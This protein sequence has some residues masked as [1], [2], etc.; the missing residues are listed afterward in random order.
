MNELVK[1]QS[2]LPSTL[3]DLSKFVLIGSEKL[4]VIKAEIKAI[5]KAELA[6]EVYYQKLEEQR[7][8]SDLILD[9]STRM[10]DLSKNL[11]KAS[12]MRKDVTSLLR[13]NEVKTKTEILHNLGFSRKQ[14]HEFEILAENKDLVELEKAK[15]SEEKRPASRVNVVELAKQR[16]KREE[17]ECQKDEDFY[18][19]LDFCGKTAKK[20]NDVIFDLKRLSVDDRH[21]T[22]WARLLDSRMVLDSQIEAVEVA[23]PKLI[24]IQKFLKELKI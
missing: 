14:A 3:D 5:T 13:G 20:F 21:L 9:A 22:A 23:L 15:A 19:Y 2:N 16:K 24:K 6:T 4:K 1:T 12:G 11:P 10:G 7:I 8:L 18:A 17:E